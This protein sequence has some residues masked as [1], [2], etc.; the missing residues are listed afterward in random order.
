MRVNGTITSV[1]QESVEVNP[2]DVIS[3]IKLDWMKSIDV[4]SYW[5]INQEGVWEDWEDT[6]GSGI[7]NEHRQATLDEIHKWVLFKQFEGLVNFMYK[8]E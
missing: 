3:Q 8:G 5:Y 4:C 2:S 6:H 7:T 1:I